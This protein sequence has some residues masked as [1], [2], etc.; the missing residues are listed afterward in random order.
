MIT[1]ASEEVFTIECDICGY[2]I[3]YFYEDGSPDQVI[4]DDNWHKTDSK[5][6][7]CSSCYVPPFPDLHLDKWSIQD[8][9]LIAPQRDYHTRKGIVDNIDVELVTDELRARYE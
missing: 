8:L 4:A 9:L 3:A 6:I 2:N 1:Q 7:H 5:D